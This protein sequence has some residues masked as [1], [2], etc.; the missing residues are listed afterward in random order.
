MI[1][2]LYLDR[3]FD[4]QLLPIP[5]SRYR[6]WWEEDTKTK[7]HAKF[8]LPMVMANSY[9]FYLLSPADIS[10]KWSGKNE[11]NAEVAT[12][13]NSTHGVVD[14][15]SA[16]GSFTIQAK[17]IPRTPSNVFTLIK[18]LPNVKMPFTVLEGLM[19]TWWLVADFGIV[20]L[21]NEP[22]E[23][24]IPK[25]S[26]IAQMVFIGSQ[27]HNYELQIAGNM[28]DLKYR[29]EFVTKRNAYTEKQLDYFRGNHAEGTKESLHYKKFNNASPNNKEFLV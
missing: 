25:G 1:I 7:N 16:H 15:H 26:P 27:D 29:D 12:F 8:C 2:D 11:D 4:Q 19:E 6:R 20:C 18:P 13:N 22:G 28:E 17:F 14:N 24:H 23:F 5:A 10:I 21:V 3:K 9:G